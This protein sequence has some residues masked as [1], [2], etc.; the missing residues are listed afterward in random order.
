MSGTDP[1]ETFTHDGYTIAIH[2]DDDCP[3]P[4]EDSCQLGVFVGLPHRRYRIGDEQIDP[5]TYTFDCPACHGTGI[6]TAAH[7]DK[8]P[9]FCPGCDGEGGRGAGNMAEFTHRLQAERQARVLL[10]VG[11]LDHSGIAYYIGSGPHRFDP[12]GWDSGL[13]GFIFDTPAT[14][15][16]CWGE[17]TPTDEQISEA[18]TGEIAVY[19]QWANGECFGYTVTAPDGEEIDACWGYLGTDSWW[20]GSGY[21]IDQARA[22]IDAHRAEQQRTRT[23]LFQRLVTR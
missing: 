7:A 14:L 22:A 11:M 2:Y 21:L 3:N 19:S 16:E 23:A 13:A 10:P 8:E 15:A 4:R 5:G 1:V 12:Q 18:L 20:G 6:E 17:A 9:E